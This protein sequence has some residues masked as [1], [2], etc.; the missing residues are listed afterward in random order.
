MTTWFITGTDTGVGKTEVAAA[1]GQYLQ[2][3]GRKVLPQKWVQTGC[4]EDDDLSVHRQALGLSDEDLKNFGAAMRPYAFSLAASAHLAAKEEGVKINPEKIIQCLRFLEQRCDDVVVEGLGGVNV[5][6]T[7]DV[8]A[9]DML[10]RLKLKTLVVVDNKVGA[11]NHALLTIEAIATR[12]IPIEGF[13]MNT[14]KE[15]N[16]L[17]LQDN[18]LII[19]RLSGVRCVGEMGNDKRLS[20]R[21]S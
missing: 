6:L 8:T 5:P 2:G 14:F 13:V 21:L 4:L 17:V 15:G 3:K 19:E 18:P 1:F 11:I 10:E 7:E 20:L 16:D 9:L 12:K